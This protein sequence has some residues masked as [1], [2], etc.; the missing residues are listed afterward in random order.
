MTCKVETFH[1]GKDDQG[2][3]LVE[4]LVGAA[5]V[6]LA[7][8]AI[9]NLFPTA[10]SNITYGGNQTLATSYAQQKIEQLKNL[11]FNAIDTTSCS[12]LSENLGN[13]F[14][15]SCILTN[16]VGVGGLAGDL[17]K[18]QVTVAFPGQFRPGTF[19]AETL[20]TR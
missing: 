19:S 11:A 10:Y 14:S 16:N 4:G 5:L 15:R 1:I 7:F 17:K 18:V 9:S 6:A 20:F 8:I 2:F 13:G 12:N 3:T